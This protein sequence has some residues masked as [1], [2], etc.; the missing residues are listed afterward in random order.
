MS[1]FEVFEVWGDRP[2][3]IFAW[4][5]V[6]DR[7]ATLA[8]SGNFPDPGEAKAAAAAAV[9]LIRQATYAQRFP[10]DIAAAIPIVDA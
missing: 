7:G 6:D 2:L 8:L 10:E 3:G 9:L 1:G 5:L 4:R